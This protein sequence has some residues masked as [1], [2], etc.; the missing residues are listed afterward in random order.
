MKCYYLIKY[1]AAKRFISMF[2]CFIKCLLTEYNRRT[3]LVNFFLSGVECLAAVSCC[4]TG[5]M[6]WWEIWGAWL[7][8]KLGRAWVCLC[9]RL[10]GQEL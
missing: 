6:S 8:G 7:T 1:Y 10:Y 2:R 9:N 5:Y 3:S 4:S